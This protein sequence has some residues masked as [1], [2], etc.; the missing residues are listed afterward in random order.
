MPI[1]RIKSHQS[2]LTLI[3]LMVAITLGIFVLSGLVY[4][5]S[6]SIKTNTET[7]RSTQLNQELRGTLHLIIR[8]LRRAGGFNDASDAITF[9]TSHGLTLSA[10]SGTG[11]TITTNPAAQFDDWV[12]AGVV[13]R[14]ASLDIITGD[15]TN[16]CIT[17]TNRNSNTQLTGSNTACPGDASATAFPST[18]AGAS[19][20]I[21]ENAFTTK[22]IVTDA[23]DAADTDYTCMIFGYD[24]DKDN[25]A[26]SNENY[27]YR[28]DNAEQAVETWQSGTVACNDGVWANVTDEATVDI[29]NFLITRLTPIGASVL[30]YKISISG[31]LQA[32]PEYSRTVEDVVRVRN[33]PV[34]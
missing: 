9:S 18:T 2:G 6:S 7:L 21:F 15:V 34:L 5:I 11:I 20:W 29:T 3:E 32:H 31:R 10:V 16:S 25:V 33:D 14:T 23:A 28:Y 27:G 19:S 22:D 1:I 8:D 12:V 30:E 17:V 26:D 4:I 13:I 24:K